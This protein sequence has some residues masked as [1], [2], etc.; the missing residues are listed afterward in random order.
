MSGSKRDPE[1]QA[2]LHMVVQSHLDPSNDGP[3]PP[4][5]TAPGVG[6]SETPPFK[7]SDFAFCVCF[8]MFMTSYKEPTS[9]V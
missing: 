8:W 4:W 2:Q 6:V 3:R 9:M 1:L 5:S 7:D